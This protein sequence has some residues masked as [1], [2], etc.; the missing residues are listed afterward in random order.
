MVIEWES[1]SSKTKILDTVY[2]IAQVPEKY[3]EEIFIFLAAQKEL[4][5]E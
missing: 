2:E 1:H 3:L 4:L 5:A